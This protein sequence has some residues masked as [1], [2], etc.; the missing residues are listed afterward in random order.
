MNVKVPAQLGDAIDR[1]AE[2]L[3]ATKTDTLLMLLNEG[4]ARVKRGKGR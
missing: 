3:G 4:L 1:L 2:H